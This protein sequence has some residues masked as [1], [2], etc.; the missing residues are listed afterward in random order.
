[1]QDA[2]AIHRRLLAHQIHHEI[3]RLPR[4]LTCF[5]DLPEVLGVPAR[6]CVGVT[7][8]EVTVRS[9]RDAV[10]VIGSVAEPPK[11][12]AVGALLGAQR[13]RLASAFL[14]NA[15]TDYAAGLVGPL[16]LPERL[17]ALIDQR[18]IDHTDPDEFLHT[19]TGERSTVLRLR[20][21]HLFALVDAKPVDL[22]GNGR[23]S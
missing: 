11:P 5:D 13:V 16:L 12:A 21:I 20:A 4:V 14:V 15:V 6:T 19:A 2:L 8:F 17:T 10:A 1:M 22:T 23:T 7:V 18:L 9:V 3:V